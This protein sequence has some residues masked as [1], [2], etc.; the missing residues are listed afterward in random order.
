VLLQAGRIK[1]RCLRVYALQA[2]PSYIGI[3]LWQFLP[4]SAIR[5]MSLYLSSTA[6]TLF[7]TLPAF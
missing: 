4:L 5:L 7:D 6:A 2:S 3:T 1:P